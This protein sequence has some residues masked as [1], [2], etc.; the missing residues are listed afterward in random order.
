MESIKEIK[1]NSKNFVSAYKRFRLYVFLTKVTS[2]T[3]LF[4]TTYNSNCRQATTD[5]SSTNRL[6]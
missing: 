5:F 3:T 6:R 2:G 1:I 4:N